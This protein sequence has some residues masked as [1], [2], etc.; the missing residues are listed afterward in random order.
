MTPTLLSFTPDRLTR[1]L[2]D[3]VLL[4]LLALEAAFWLGLM[5]SFC[6]P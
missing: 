1:S 3:R 4:S 6:R 2:S 5:I